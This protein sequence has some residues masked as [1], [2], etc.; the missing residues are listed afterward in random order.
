MVMSKGGRTGLTPVCTDRAAKLVARS[1]P[2]ACLLCELS[3]SANS[4]PVYMRGHRL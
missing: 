3:R 1:A 2:R 4:R